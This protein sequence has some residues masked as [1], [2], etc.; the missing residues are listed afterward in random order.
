MTKYFITYVFLEGF[1]GNGWGFGSSV[2]ISKNGKMTEQDIRE[3]SKNI[4]SELN[5]KEVVIINW[6]R[7]DD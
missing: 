4:E 1:D 3:I 5:A 7:L 6:N 2:V